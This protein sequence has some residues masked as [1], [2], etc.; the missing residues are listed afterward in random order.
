MRTIMLPLL[1]APILL[2]G[3]C[4]RPQSETQGVSRG[5]LTPSNLDANRAISVAELQAAYFGLN[6]KTV[7]VY[8]YPS[9]V[10]EN[11]MI[12]NSIS[13]NTAPFGKRVLDCELKAPI[14]DTKLR[15][16]PMVLRGIIK[17]SPYD[18]VTL[19]G[20]ELM[21]SGETATMPASRERTEN[22]V[23]EAA[24]F[25]AEYNAWKGKQ[26]T[27]TGNYHSTTTSTNAYAKTIRVDLTDSAGNKAVGA[28]FAED[29]SEKMLVNRENVE[30]QCTIKGTAFDMVNLTGCRLLNR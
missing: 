9:F 4:K 20:C 30:M 28:E 27:V 3:N 18:I 23:M 2:T 13:L 15:D 10:S 16:Q 25:V 5:Q 19:T 1:L 29:P 26:V 22:E 21:K 8:G 17:E 14:A 24:A 7:S 6:G 11:G 12:Q